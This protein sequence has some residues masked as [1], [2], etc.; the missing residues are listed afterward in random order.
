MLGTSLWC[1]S[2]GGGL[3]QGRGALPAVLLLQWKGLPDK[4]G[5]QVHHE[6]GRTAGRRVITE[7]LQRDKPEPHDAGNKRQLGVALKG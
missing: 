5:R 2:S 3:T 4:A 7:T 6:Q 1:W